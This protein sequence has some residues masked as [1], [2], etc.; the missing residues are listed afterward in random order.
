[1]VTRTRHFITLCM[2]CPSFFS[3]TIGH[4][5]RLWRVELNSKQYL[6]FGDIVWTAAA[7]SATRQPRMTD[8]ER[9]F[10]V[11]CLCTSAQWIL[12]TLRQLQFDVFVHL[13]YIADLAP[14]ECNLLDSAR[15]ATRGHWFAGVQEV[16]VLLLL[17]WLVCRPKS[18]AFS[19]LTE[20]SSPLE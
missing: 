13:P 20:A 5:A 8:V 4:T 15:D 14:S 11:A 1:M 12:E 2:Q 9:C 10:I 17:A 6:S 3:L 7:C 18:F 19:G 16:K